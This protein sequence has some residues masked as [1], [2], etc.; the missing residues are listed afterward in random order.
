MEK[1][2]KILENNFHNDTQNEIMILSMQCILVVTY[3]FICVNWQNYRTQTSNFK[4]LDRLILF[5]KRL[6]HYCKYELPAC[7]RPRLQLSPT[8]LETYWWIINTKWAARSVS[9]SVDGELH[10]F[11]LYFDYP[12][13][14]L[15]LHLVM[16]FDFFY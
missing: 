5:E 1:V 7:T 13:T 2:S 8:F 9:L 4:L 16:I 11:V 12:C 3:K 15:V 10:E 14:K 6:M